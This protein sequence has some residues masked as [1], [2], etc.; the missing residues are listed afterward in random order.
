MIQIRGIA[1]LVV[2]ATPGAALVAVAAATGAPRMTS[3][4]RIPAGVIDR[5]SVLRKQ[6]SS[7]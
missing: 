7:P 3:F 5:A 1:S 6:E 4:C 2:D